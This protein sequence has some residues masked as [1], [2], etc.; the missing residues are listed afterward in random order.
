MDC[1]DIDRLIDLTQ[2]ERLDLPAHA[3][4]RGCAECRK[5]LRLLEDLRV[6]LRAEV[7]VPERLLERAF[8]A[9]IPV[10]TPPG[11]HT[12]LRH[13]LSAAVLGTATAFATVVATGSAGEAGPLDVALFSL[14]F[15]GLAVL[16]ELRRREAGT[17]RE[18]ERGQRFG[19]GEHG[20]PG[21]AA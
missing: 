17:A 11:A 3:H 12:G 20:P 14:G 4:V 18:R 16:Y 8:L 5:R 7:M 15:G 10:A 2:D 21:A 6:G 13:G 19:P 1:L 9:A